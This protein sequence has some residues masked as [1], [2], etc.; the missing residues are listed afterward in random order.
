MTG[1]IQYDQRNLSWKKGIDCVS[2]LTLNG[3][4]QLPT[5][6][7]DYQRARASLGLRGQTDLIYEIV[8]ST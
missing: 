5:R 7:G 3:R 1:A 8:Y 6:V 2:L 4:L